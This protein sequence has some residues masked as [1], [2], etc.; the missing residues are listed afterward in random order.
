VS[1]FDEILRPRVAPH[2]AT[3]P[4]WRTALLWYVGLQAGAVATLP[5]WWTGW[6]LLDRWFG[7]IW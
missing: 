2:R 1:E 6:H 5:T 4:V 7:W 3:R